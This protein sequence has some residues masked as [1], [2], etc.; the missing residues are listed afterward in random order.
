MAAWCRCLREI[1]GWNNDKHTQD[2]RDA[3]D[4][5]L[6]EFSEPLDRLVVAAA[7]AV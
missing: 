7:L 4:Q 2:L 6:A 5:L 1:I 3:A